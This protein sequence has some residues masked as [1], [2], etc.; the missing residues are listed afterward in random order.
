M[1]IFVAGSMQNNVENDEYYKSAEEIGNIIAKK[2]W[3]IVFGGS[4]N[5]TIGK[6]YKTAQKK[7]KVNIVTT[8]KYAHEAETIEHQSLHLADTLGERVNILIKESNAMLFLPGGAGTIQELFTALETKDSEHNTPIVIYNQNG[9]FDEILQFMKKAKNLGFTRTNY[10]EFL[11][12]ATNTGEVENILTAIE[13]GEAQPTANTKNAQFQERTDKATR[14]F[15]DDILECKESM[16]QCRAGQASIGSRIWFE[17]VDKKLEIAICDY[18]K[19]YMSERM[20]D[21]LLEYENKDE[22][23]ES[24]SQKLDENDKDFKFKYAMQTLSCTADP[25]YDNIDAENRKTFDQNRRTLGAY[26]F[27]IIWE[28]AHICKTKDDDGAFTKEGM[29]RLRRNEQT[30]DNLKIIKTHSQN[31]QQRNL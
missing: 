14:K 2:N 19:E 6:L 24:V 7:S 15:F 25:H 20:R 21:K 18:L 13:K 8:P 1:K 31:N 12:I 5:G 4:Q 30:L 22:A 11:K 9:Y 26:A 28:H 10:E 17:C 16:K 23:L 27:D 3:E 29:A